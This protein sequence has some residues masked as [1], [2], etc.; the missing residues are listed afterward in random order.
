SAAA[1]RIFAMGGLIIAGPPG[2]ALFEVPGYCFAQGQPRTVEAR[3]H[4]GDGDI[5]DLSRLFGR[6][7]LDVA[8]QEDGL[9]DLGQLVDGGLEPAAQLVALQLVVGT[10]RPVVARSRDLPVRVE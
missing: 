4:G 3:L 1:A 10:P 2:L 9:V 8:D 6:E 5:Q 7:P